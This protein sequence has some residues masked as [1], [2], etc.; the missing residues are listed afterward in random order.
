MRL[1]GNTPDKSK[2]IRMLIE[3]KQIDINGIDNFQATHLMNAVERGEY[4]LVETLLSLKADWRKVDHVG[5]PV[6]T[7][8]CEKSSV[9]PALTE[10]D[11]IRTIQVLIKYGADKNAKDYMGRDCR[12]MA[13]RDGFLKLAE[14]F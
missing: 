5:N 8:V 4:E 10:E 14:I 3:Q 2:V 7:R 12:D 11:R 9:Y 1:Y 13:E 6:L